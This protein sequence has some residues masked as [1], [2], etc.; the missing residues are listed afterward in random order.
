M[1]NKLLSTTALVAATFLVSPLVAGKASAEEP[2]ELTIGGYMHAMTIW[3]ASWDDGTGESAEGL[4]EFLINEEGEIQFTAKTTLD[5]GLQVGVRVEFENSN[6]S[7][8]AAHVDERY[9]WFS[10]DFGRV[11]IGSDDNAAYTMHYQAPSVTGAMVDSP[12]H[13]YPTAGG[14]EASTGSYPGLGGDGQKIIYFTPRISGFQLGVSY[15]P[16]DTTIEGAPGA[17]G[18][19]DE[20]IGKQSD[21]FAI[22][23]NFTDSFNGVDVAVS[24]GYVR[25]E[26]ESNAGVTTTTI[27]G[28]CGTSG[29]VTFV[30]TTT[31]GGLS[32]DRQV[33]V[34]GLNVGFGGFT[35]GGAYKHDDNGKSAST[36]TDLYAIG[37]TYGTGP[38]TVGAQYMHSETEDAVGDDEVDAYGIAGSYTLGPGISVWSSLKFYD[39]KDDAG[40]PSDENEQTV[41]LLGTSIKF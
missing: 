7:A 28:L 1:Q 2:L 32:D 12:T 8:G 23:L 40:A 30:V 24:G 18:V 10:G 41:F 17:V 26:L 25:G 22:G 15:Q 37:V 29:N 11:T 31:A 6:Q 39:F 9:V 33:W 20:D 19:G 35:I 3:N 16:D 14:N 36:D 4:R 5:N 13:G 34:A 38:W 21:I 27:C